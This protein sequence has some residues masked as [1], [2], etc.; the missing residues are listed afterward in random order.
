[1]RRVHGC[2]R[3]RLTEKLGPTG[4]TD[5]NV[6]AGDLKEK[7]LPVEK[8][9]VA[10]ADDLEMGDCR[11]GSGF[12]E[13]SGPVEFRMG[14]AGGEEPEVTDTYESWREHVSKEALNEV[15]GV[16]GYE[17]FGSGLLVVAGAECDGL[18]V[19]CGKALVGNGHPVGVMTEIAEDVF[20]R[21]E[22]RLGVRVPFLSS[23]GS[24]E[25]FEG[26]GSFQIAYGLRKAESGFIEELLEAVEELS[27]EHLCQ[28]LDG[29][30]EVVFRWCPS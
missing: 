1:M 5:G 10:G 27:S 23:Q 19:E 6:E 15:S 3:D 17:P 29:N 21:V 7:T 30:E 28:G 2:G 16:E 11:V 20:R 24:D 9:L 4:R 13:L 12:N 22:G 14:V 26:R 8:E 18:P 25:P